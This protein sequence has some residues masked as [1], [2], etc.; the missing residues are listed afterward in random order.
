[1]VLLEKISNLNVTRTSNLLS[2]ELRR[3]LLFIKQIIAYN[4]PFKRKNMCRRMYRIFKDRHSN[5][6]Y[7]VRSDPLTFVV[8]QRAS[9][10]TASRGLSGR[11]I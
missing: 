8:V 5:L 9:F 7:S 11:V 4:F 3:R 1:M 6:L 10:V 2:F